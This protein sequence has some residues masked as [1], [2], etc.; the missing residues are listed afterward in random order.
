M[1][2]TL[3]K[4]GKIR[5]KAEKCGSS[6]GVSPMVMVKGAAGRSTGPQ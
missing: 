3:E 2:G 5:M 4:E 1:H 6:L